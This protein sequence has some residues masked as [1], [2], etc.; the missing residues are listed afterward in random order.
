MPGTSGP[1]EMTQSQFLHLQQEYRD[2]DTGHGHLQIQ[3]QLAASEGWGGSATDAENRRRLAFHQETMREIGQLMSRRNGRTLI[4]QL[5]T[6]RHTTTI[7]MNERGHQFGGMDTEPTAGTDAAWQE[8]RNP[9]QGT[10]ATVRI[11]EDLGERD[12]QVDRQGGGRTSMPNYIS[13]GHE[14]IHAEHENLG[15]DAGP[16]NPTDTSYDTAEEERTI[17]VPS[18]AAPGQ[19]TEDMLRAEH[20]LDQRVSHAGYDDRYQEQRNVFT[21][22]TRSV[23]AGAPRRH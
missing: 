20:G 15:I 17:A 11:D 23:Y 14:L 6:G 7:Q 18:T 19:I 10:D 13:L 22:E 5:E 1:E 4:D 12:V 8:A 2:I 21:G 16:T 3:G 9:V